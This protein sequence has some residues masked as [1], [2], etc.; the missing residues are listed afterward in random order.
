MKRR[1]GVD[2]GGKIR[3]ELGVF[4]TPLILSLTLSSHV[5]E[6]NDRYNHTLKFQEDKVQRNFILGFNYQ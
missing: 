4:L 3:N 6:A 1:V 2:V 5:Y